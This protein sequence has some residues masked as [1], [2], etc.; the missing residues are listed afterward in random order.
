M[1]ARLNEI[2]RHVSC[3]PLIDAG[4][5]QEA[6]RLVLNSVCEGLQI[7]R[8][9]VWFMDES[10]GGIR[11]DLLID[12]AN[13]TESTDILLTEAD[14]PRYF[15]GLHSERA[16][17][18]N[19]ARH[20]P[21]T[22]E[23]REGYLVPLGVTSMMDVP[24]RHHG[25]MIGIIC[26][27]H[28]GPMRQWNADEVT[29]AG[30]LGDLVGRAINAREALAARD[31]AEAANA[32]KS[33]FLA[34][35][36]HELRTPMNGVLGMGQLLLMPGV[37]EEERK[38]YA[39]SILQSGQE[40][41]GLLNEVL[42]YASVEAGTVAL[43]LSAQDPAVL[44]HEVAGQFA[45]R[46]ACAGLPL[47]AHWQGPAEHYLVDARRVQQMLAHYL[48]NAFKFTER[49]EVAISATVLARHAAVSV[50]E[51][52]VSDTGIG[53]PADQQRELFHPFSPCDTS[54][55]RKHGGTGLGLATVR[56]LAEQMDGEAGVEARPGGGS[57][58]WFRIRVANVANV[59]TSA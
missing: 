38:E 24:I 31:V 18:A 59:A 15:A 47:R 27:E 46:A 30:G 55:T 56:R 44:L 25:R 32:A 29:F 43:E 17:V 52:S 58:F 5:E 2:M 12:R 54:T 40:L 37:T 10:A 23:F 7:A 42:E 14:Y 4:R 34:T 49:G 26:A 13:G 8:A 9:G 50:L 19:D 57:R 39:Q 48:T 11:C 33:R 21:A 22:S 36:S 51:F 41:L 53:V 28:T 20:D 16:I 6:I 3:S 1:E 45:E 35:M